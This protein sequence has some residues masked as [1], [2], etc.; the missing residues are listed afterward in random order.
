MEDSKKSLTPAFWVT[1]ASTR[2]SHVDG[3]AGKLIYRGYPI[4]TC[5]TK[6][7]LK[8][9]FICCSMNPCPM[10]HSLPILPGGSRKT[11]PSG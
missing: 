8:R 2:I 6:P 9:L 10:K 7:V 5:R 3:E 11:G 1:V 4:L